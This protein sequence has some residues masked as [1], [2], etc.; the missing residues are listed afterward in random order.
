MACGTATKRGSPRPRIPE[1]RLS[2]ARQPACA[3]PRRPR[4]HRRNLMTERGWEELRPYLLR[5]AAAGGH[6]R[7]RPRQAG[8]P[9]KA[10]DVCPQDARPP[11]GGNPVVSASVLDAARDAD[12]GVQPGGPTRP[13]HQRAH[14][15]SAD[16][17]P[18]ADRARQGDP[19]GRPPADDRDHVLR[20]GPDQ[21]RLVDL[22]QPAN[23]LGYR[24]EHLLRRSRP[25]QQHRHPPQRGLLL[26]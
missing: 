11:T 13:K 26:R 25:G 23:F 12:V 10:R 7:R 9:R 1:I 20:V 19:G 15:P 3:V 6:H 14:V 2:I 5:R 4:D 18:A 22:Q 8:Y 16:L 17:E 24:R 21:D